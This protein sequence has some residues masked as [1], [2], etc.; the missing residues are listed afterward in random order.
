M[1]IVTANV[2]LLPFEIGKTRSLYHRQD[3]VTFADKSGLSENHQGA[4]R[5]DPQFGCGF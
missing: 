2:G 3:G 5:V 1:I 4:K